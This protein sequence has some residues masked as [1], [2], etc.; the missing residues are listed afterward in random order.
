MLDT[1]DTKCDELS[2]KVSSTLSSLTP[3]E[4]W[5]ASPPEDE[6]VPE[7]AIQN[8]IGRGA[9]RCLGCL[10]PNAR[11]RG[12]QMRRAL[13]EIEEIHGGVLGIEHWEQGIRDI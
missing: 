6:P 7:T 9:I 2:S 11:Y 5:Q 4:R 8:A 12:H 10:A 13:V 1:E 3:M